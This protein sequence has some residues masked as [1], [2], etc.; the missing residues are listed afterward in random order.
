[1]M[2]RLTTIL[3]ALPPLDVSFQVLQVE[4]IRGKPHGDSHLNDDLIAPLSR[5]LRDGLSFLVH[6]LSDLALLL[7]GHGEVRHTIFSG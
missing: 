5:T 7:L 1:M 2:V 6:F 4:I 3:A